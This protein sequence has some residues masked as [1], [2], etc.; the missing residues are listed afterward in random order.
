MAI[1]PKPQ[2]GHSGNKSIY[3]SQEI[4][5]TDTFCLLSSN[6]SIFILP[7]INTGLGG[8][9]QNNVFVLF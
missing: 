9:I 2:R 5:S 8:L 6:E 7:K 3:S 4:L 1:F